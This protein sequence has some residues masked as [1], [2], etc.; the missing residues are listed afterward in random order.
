MR[1]RKQ[2]SL[3]KRLDNKE[4][5]DR[6]LELLGRPGVRSVDLVS[7]VVRLRLR[8]VLVSR[9]RLLR[10]LDKLKLLHHS[11]VVVS[12]QQRHLVALGR[13]Q[14]RPRSVAVAVAVR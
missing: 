8:L 11:A 7:E 6:K 9:H 10:L 2:E 14:E 13:V 3:G 1:G 4:H 5:L 12:A